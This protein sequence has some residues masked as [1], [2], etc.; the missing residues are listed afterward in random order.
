VNRLGIN[1][2]FAVKRWVE[3]ERW[4]AMVR[5]TLG[6]T[7]V[8]FSF[9]LL[10]PWWP[11]ELRTPLIRRIRTATEAQGLTLH[12]AFVGLAAYTY[13]ALLHP[14]PEGRKA[15]LMWYRRAVEVAAE[16]GVPAIGGPVGGMSVAQHT[17]AAQR[18]DRY[19]ELLEHLT[20]LTDYAARQGLREWLIEPTPLPRET[21]TTPDEA[22]ALLTELQGQTAIPVRY[23]L[24]VGH[25]LYRPLY[26]E[27]V[28][29]EPWLQAGRVAAVHLQ[30]TDGQS[31]AHWG[32][33]REGI[34]HPQE[35][36]ALLDGAGLTEVP[37]ILE[38][39]YPFE[40]ADDDVARDIAASVAYCKAALALNP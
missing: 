6:L 24:D 12:S 33:T 37:L 9:D 18:R 7:L 36:R 34:I 39:F 25:A 26:G 35:V 4:A 31:D 32:F 22:Q 8:Q 21:P 11:S 40:A 28:R 14:E 27:T 20:E 23:C 29:L 3:P 5:E 13:N 10:D 16:L 2:S 17:V 30:Q 19:R 1:L 15:A 38:V